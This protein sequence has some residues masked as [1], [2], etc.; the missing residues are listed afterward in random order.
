M[1]LIIYVI[2]KAQLMDNLRLNNCI[3]PN[4]LTYPIQI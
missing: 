2:G 1:F 3:L 4:D